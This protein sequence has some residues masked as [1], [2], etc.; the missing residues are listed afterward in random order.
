MLVQSRNSRRLGRRV[1]SARWILSLAAA[2]GIFGPRAALAGNVSISRVVAGAATIQ[3]AGNNT[4]IHAANKTIINYTQFNIASGS[5]VQFIQPSASS[6]VLNRIVTATPSQIDGTL[7]ANGII[8]LVD[9]A[10]VMFGKNSVINVGQLY[11][12]AGNISN[13]DALAGVNHFASLSG[14]VVNQGTIT[15]ADVYLVGLHVVNG[16]SIV[17]GSGTVALVA[18]QDVYLTSNPNDSGL[19]VKISAAANAATTA[20]VGVEND[21]NISAQVADMSAGDLYS[22]AIRQTGNTK[23]S[24]I[25]LNGQGAVDVSGT[26]D[27]SSATGNGGTVKVLG[28]QVALSGA[29]IDASGTTGGG[30]VWIGGGPHGTGGVLTSSLTSV[31]P[32]STINANATVNGNGGNVVVWSDQQTV[33]DGSISL[34]GGPDGGNGG[35]AEVSS[36]DLLG[37]AGNVDAG[38]PMGSVGTLLLDPHTITI[39][40]GGGAS[41]SDVASFSNTSD[42]SI[43]AGTIDVANANVVLQANTDI[44]VNQSIN[45]TTSGVSLTMQAGRSIVFASGMSITTNDGDVTLSAN[46]NTATASD[47]DAGTAV[48]TMDG[49]N[50]INAGSGAISL[51]IG[52]LGAGGSLAAGNL[53]TTGSV[54]LTNAAG[55]VDVVGAVNGGS[56]SSSGN[57]FFNFGGPITTSG[58]INI[59]QTGA[60]TIGAALNADDVNLTS[61]NAQINLDVASSTSSPAITTVNNQFFASPV[62]LEAATALTSTGGENITF[63]STVDGAFSLT[64]NSAGVIAFDNLVGSNTALATL[65]VDDTT[66]GISGGTLVLSAEGSTAIPSIRTSGGQTYNEAIM[67]NADGVFTDVGGSPI[68]F[69]ST[70]DGGFNL[71]VNTAGTTTFADDVGQ[72]VNLNAVLIDDPAS[73][74]AG[75]PVVCTFDGVATHPTILTT[76]GQTYNT[77]IVMENATAFDDVGNG[78]IT[79][80]STINGAFALSIN[81]AGDITFAGLVGH[82]TPVASVTTDDPATLITGG[83]LILNAA[84]TTAIPSITTT[85]GQTYNTPITLGANTTFTDTGGGDI[86]FN[87][88]VDGTFS[89]T[90]N[91]AGTTTF[92]DDVGQNVQ[93]TSVLIDD[94]ASGIVGGPVVCTFDGVATHPTILTTAGQTYNSPIVMQNDTAFDDVDGG[95]IT[96]NNTI[97]GAFPL[98]L[99]TTGSMTINGVIGGTTPVDSVTTDDP[100]TNINNGTTVF[101]LESSAVNPVVITTG[102][103]TY[104]NPIVLK[105]DTFLVDNGGGT[106]QFLNTVNGDGNGPW[107]LNVNTSASGTAGDIVFGNSNEGFVGAV[108]PL[109]SLTTTATGS[110]TDGQ[111]TFNMSDT[112]SAA[113]ATTEGQTYNNPVLVSDDTVLVS[114]GDASGPGFIT[115]NSTLDGS[116]NL[117]IDANYTFSGTGHLAN[118]SGG[119]VTFGNGGADFIGSITAL[120]SLTIEANG[121]GTGSPGT[122]TFN[123]VGNAN[124]SVTTTQ[125]IGIDTPI[126]LQADT[127][128]TSEDGTISLASDVTGAAFNLNLDTNSGGDNILLSADVVVNS[129]TV[130]SGVSLLVTNVTTTGNITLQPNSSIEEGPE[131]PADNRPGGVIVIGGNLTSTDGDVLLATTGRTSV[132]TTSTIANELNLN[133]NVTIDALGLTMGQSE[134]M[135]VTGNLTI[136]VGNGTATLGDINTGGNLSVT[137]GSVV[138]LRRPS[139]DIL[140]A[141]DTLMSESATSP[142]G[143]VDVV[144][145]GGMVFNTPSV[146]STG[147]GPAPKFATLSGK[148]T[149]PGQQVL[150]YGPGFGTALVDSTGTPLDLQAR[151]FTIETLAS[152]LPTPSPA[153]FGPPRTYGP[154]DT[155]DIRPALELF[156]GSTPANNGPARGTDAVFVRD[157]ESL[158][159]LDVG[160]TSQGLPLYSTQIDPVKLEAI[161][162]DLNDA[163]ADYEATWGARAIEPAAFVMY[164]EKSTLPGSVRTL[165]RLKK[166]N[167]MMQMANEKNLSDDEL[168]RLQ[169]AFIQPAC[170]NSVSY[171]DLIRVVQATGRP[172]EYHSSYSRY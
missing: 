10:G 148:G 106:I 95:D 146:T 43:D 56:F 76:Q 83:T 46:D 51:S 152:S 117:V 114:T 84:G 48:I 86:T 4:I 69:N 42:E 90:V 24:Q 107:N 37:F 147:T 135:T 75:G 36:G 118:A 60:I 96:F 164:L 129:L 41:L 73:G 25:N 85:G 140:T 159:C 156:L 128:M 8:Y 165:D 143:G 3:Q 92:A 44:D 6:W 88:T 93:L 101:A 105:A 102:G 50:T 82:T 17:A 139:G 124:P 77:P 49:S 55:D 110:I 122:T 67:M 131:G 141:N 64:L 16:G 103:Q 87:S 27:A 155:L 144:S 38:A 162:R 132:P 104:N 62:V 154:T 78:N 97:N 19:L 121:V 72:N 151:S 170:C 172:S 28:D 134:K 15:A 58:D 167:E 160:I 34:R 47:R 100:A 65:L 31:D 99:N 98:A 80:N 163:V 113:V 150:L 54:T 133:N 1:K 168:N 89:M 91:T 153:V 108:D 32:E 115:F 66:S 171:E 35:W 142:S 39:V 13:S 111:T 61:S 157:L 23:A 127:S 63:N 2:A 126:V 161:H 26:L 119:N 71:T 53:V 52:T 125:N 18:G 166:L 7:T 109:K 136:N 130:D 116:N 70:V 74:I 137:A 45:M 169:I 158:Y 21:G 123:I 68:T 138:F 79:F 29:T 145:L 81:T 22:V 14:S 120:T 40:S 112:N 5:S 57:N 33:F 94:P 11:A 12:A 149:V 9:P 20:G 59:N 30:T